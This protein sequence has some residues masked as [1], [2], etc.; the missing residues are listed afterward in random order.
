MVRCAVLQD[1]I[2]T[3]VALPLL[4]PDFPQIFNVLLACF[5][6]VLGQPFVAAERKD[7]VVDGIQS[8]LGFNRAQ[9][10]RDQT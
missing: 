8:C 7:C 1:V 9:D 2:I 6:V 5:V 3:C 4:V 10:I